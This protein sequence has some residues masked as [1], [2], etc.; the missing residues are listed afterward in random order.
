MARGFSTAVVRPA[1]NELR[2]HLKENGVE[3]DPR[4]VATALIAVFRAKVRR[5]DDLDGLLHWI[6]QLAMDIVQ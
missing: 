2:A 3:T 6:E 5:K 4:L 1:L